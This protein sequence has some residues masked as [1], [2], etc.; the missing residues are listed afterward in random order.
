MSASKAY[1]WDYIEAIGKVAI[2]I[3][4]YSTQQVVNYSAVPRAIPIAPD[5]GDIPEFAVNITQ[6]EAQVDPNGTIFRTV[7]V[8]NLAPFNPVA[9]DLLGSTT[10]ITL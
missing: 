7:H 6:G 4:G 3:H 1:F 8:Q 5:P 2:S 9:V 10:D